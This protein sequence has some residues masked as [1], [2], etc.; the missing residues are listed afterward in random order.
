MNQKQNYCNVY[1]ILTNLT[2]AFKST[3]KIYIFCAIYYDFYNNKKCNAYSS[4]VF[5]VLLFLILVSFKH[6]SSA[7]QFKFSSC[8]CT[9]SELECGIPFG[10][11]VLEEVSCDKIHETS[12]T[13]S[14]F[15]QLQYSTCLSAQCKYANWGC[16]AIWCFDPLL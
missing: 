16:S 1:L 6:S 8:M 5:S 11:H 2:F 14:F 7:F 9:E 15:P 4:N 3:K 13:C 10:I 12:L